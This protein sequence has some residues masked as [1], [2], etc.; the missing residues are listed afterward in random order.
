M[1]F[2]QPG[3]ARKSSHLSPIISGQNKKRYTAR[4]TAALRA[5]RYHGILPVSRSAAVKTRGMLRDPK[6][7][8]LRGQRPSSRDRCDSTGAYRL[9]KP[10]GGG[11]GL[12]TW[13][14][15][16]VRNYRNANITW[17]F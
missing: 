4:A 15:G 11:T 5:S 6:K 8:R 7:Q 16:A 13:H 3:V 9:A 2:F 10:R 1:G 12:V 14:D 17:S